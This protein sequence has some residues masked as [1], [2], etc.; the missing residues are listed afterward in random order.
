MGRAVGRL[1]GSV[2]P[3]PLL[4][5]TGAYPGSAGQVLH[6]GWHTPSR[7]QQ[8]CGST[9][10]VTTGMWHWGHAAV[11]AAHA[12]CGQTYPGG[13]TGHAGV[14]HDGP[15]AATATQLLT[16]LTHLQGR[17]RQGVTV[18][19]AIRAQYVRFSFKVP[20]HTACQ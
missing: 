4:P 6:S 12:N 13:H 14:Q 19:F 16:P 20:K 11:G 7:L 9:G 17:Q 10:G 15:A 3:P 1:R 5:T 18:D 8:Q 2:P